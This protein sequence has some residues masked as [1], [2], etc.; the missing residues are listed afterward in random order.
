MFFKKE[1]NGNW[2]AGLI[3]HLIDGTVLDESNKIEKDGWEWLDEAPEGYII[4]DEL[5]DGY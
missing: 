4:L 1:E 5:G 2:I 3:V